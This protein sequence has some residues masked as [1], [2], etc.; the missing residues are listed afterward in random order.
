MLSVQALMA[1]LEILKLLLQGLEH[2]P[3]LLLR[4]LP[5]NLLWVQDRVCH[6][7]YFVRPHL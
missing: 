3:H 2:L 7:M 5:L 1:G 6:V 4:L